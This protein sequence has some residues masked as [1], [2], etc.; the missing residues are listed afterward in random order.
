[1]LVLKSYVPRACSINESWHVEQ[2]LKILDENSISFTTP[3]HW[4]HST[5]L[6]AC[7]K[8]NYLHSGSRSPTAIIFHH[9]S[10]FYLFFIFLPSKNSSPGVFFSC[11]FL[12]KLLL[13]HLRTSTV[14][15]CT[16]EK[17]IHPKYSCHTLFNFHNIK[18]NFLS[19]YLVPYSSVP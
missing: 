6:L 11:F 13:L 17:S 9:N 5:F 1:M 18:L 8:K 16:G 14:H 7:K 12:I 15:L 10:Q 2:F 19:V 4:I 3:S